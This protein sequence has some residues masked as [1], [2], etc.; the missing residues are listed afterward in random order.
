[1][2]QN[3][4]WTRNFLI[5]FTAN[6]FFALVY[7]LQITTLAEYAVK[8]FSTSASMA[9]L[10]ASIF[11]FGSIPGRIIA[12]KY[13]NIVGK[14]KSL[15]FG[16]GLYMLVS[17]AY[18]IPTSFG[19][20][21]LIRILHGIAFGISTTSMSTVVLDY[22]PCERRGEGIGY[23]SLSVTISTALGP[24]IGLFVSQHYSHKVIFGLCAASALFSLIIIFFLQIKE[25]KLTE[26]QV[27]SLKSGFHL[28][29]YIEK[30][31]LPICGT[32]IFWA[33]CYS[34][35][36]AFI[37]PYSK[38]IGV[39]APLFFVIYAAFILISRPITGKLIDK[40]GDNI[41]I[42]P[43]IICFA[44]GLLILGTAR[45]SVMFLLAAVP[46]ALGY[47]NLMSCSQAIAVKSAPN[48]RSGMATSTFFLSCDTGVAIGPVVLGLM[49]PLRG[50]SGM[51]ITSAVIVSASIALYYFLHGKKRNSQNSCSKD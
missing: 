8:T 35:V 7:F 17:L 14:R 16:F 39:T 50:Y 23:F 30:K 12:G 19:F 6:T 9:G 10:T 20:F 25:S 40:K 48:Y 15:F 43:A 44:V 29:N 47:G 41:V 42:Y 27:K 1:M 5:S 51:Y 13:I 21:L 4:L 2:V 34:C 11:V 24:F 37:S 46:M 32:M 33:M 18:F 28:N 38:S 31:A 26:E 36:S 3:R 45:S 49:V 22:I